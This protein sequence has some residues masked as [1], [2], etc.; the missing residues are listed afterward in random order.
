MDLT[1]V[2][3]DLLSEVQDIK[4]IDTALNSAAQS[5]GGGVN[6]FRFTC[7]GKTTEIYTPD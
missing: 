1:C 2:K 7:D 4:V 6:G 5:Q 3:M